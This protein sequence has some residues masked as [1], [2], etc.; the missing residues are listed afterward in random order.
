MCYVQDCAICDNKREQIAVMWT[1]GDDRTS[2]LFTKNVDK[3][4]CTLYKHIVE[5]LL[6]IIEVKRVDHAAGVPITL[7][8]TNGPPFDPHD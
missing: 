4:M 3:R 6:W 1:S 7:K 8:T 5:K 2:D